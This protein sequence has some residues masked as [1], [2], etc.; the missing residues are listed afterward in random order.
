M[1]N[2]APNSP[3]ISKKE[4]RSLLGKLAHVARC[5]R[6]GRAFLRRLFDLLRSLNRFKP[7][8]RKRIPSEAR[9]DLLWW[10]YHAEESNGITF[11]PA[12][13]D[14]TSCHC[15][16]DAC[17]TGGAAIFKPHWFYHKFDI[18]DSRP[19]AVKEFVMVL[20]ALQ[21]WGHIWAG[22]SVVFFVDNQNVVDIC[23]NISSKSPSLMNLLRNFLLLAAKFSIRD[24]HFQYIP[25]ENNFLADAL[26]RQNFAVVSQNPS[27][28]ASSPH[29]TSKLQMKDF[30]YA[31]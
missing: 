6:M 2:C 9:K 5:V 31:N 30:Y 22:S 16:T 21:T 19:I 25:S 26:S 4:L 14:S 7:H 8:H 10:R 18:L 17:L 29:H 15:T 28:L 23:N 24:F 1:Q 27:E 13:S 20:M 3:K 12:A 11:I